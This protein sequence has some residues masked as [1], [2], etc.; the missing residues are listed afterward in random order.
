[1]MEW[2]S[3]K[4]EGNF[5]MF[6]EY[7]EL[8]TEVYDHTKPVG[9]SIGGDIEFYRDRLASCMGRIL[10]AAVGSG[11]MLIP[12]LEAGLTVDGVDNSPEM[13]ASCRK[14]C[15]ER[16]LNP[17]LIEGNVQELALPYTYEAIVMPAG[18]FLLIEQRHESI[19]TLARFY[20]HLV[21]GGR[22][23]ID[24][25]LPD[26]HFEIGKVSTSSFALPT[27][28]LI[29]LEEKLVKVDF[30]NQCT[31]SHL[32]YEK[33]RKGRLFQ[34][35]LQRF[36]LRWYG[37][38]EFKLVLESVG[39]ANISCSADYVYGQQPSEDHQIITFEAVKHMNDE[40]PAGR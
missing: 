12:L 39:F 14:R 25:H 10:E 4:N 36:P 16:G 27:G 20:E 29:T 15:K 8:C 11:R 1:M 23:I 37:F 34:T 21:P 30:L 28:D 32:K 22:L 13:L 5:C 2:R 6:S 35:E 9:H 38:A 31:V 26:P 18:S 3:T 7:S 24:I 19:N 40:T 17:E 33:W